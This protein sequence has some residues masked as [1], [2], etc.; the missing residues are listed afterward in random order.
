VVF[1][2]F[3][4]GVQFPNPDFNESKKKYQTVATVDDD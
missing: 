3:K 2:K 1:D 4:E